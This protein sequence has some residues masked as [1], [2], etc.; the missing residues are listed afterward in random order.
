MLSLMSCQGLWWWY[1]ESALETMA[2]ARPRHWNLRRRDADQLDVIGMFRGVP[3]IGGFEVDE[4]AMALLPW[5]NGAVSAMDEKRL[6]VV[7]EPSK[8]AVG[9]GR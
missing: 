7:M 5:W 4:E 8:V 9:V 2:R 1:W 3:G 6:M